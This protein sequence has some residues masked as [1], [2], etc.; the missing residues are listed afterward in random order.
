MSLHDLLEQQ[1]AKHEA[2]LEQSRGMKSLKELSARVLLRSDL[3]LKKGSK[4]EAIAALPLPETVKV[5]L[6]EI[7]KKFADEVMKG[8]M[9]IADT[10]TDYFVSLIES[11]DYDSWAAGEGPDPAPIL[12]AQLLEKFH[13]QL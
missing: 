11:G 13:L 12:I 5:Y 3:C 2:H 1:R 9:G 7:D 8:F 10:M 4:K 6:A